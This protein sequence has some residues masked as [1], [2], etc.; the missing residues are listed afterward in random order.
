MVG[1]QLSQVGFGSLADITPDLEN[2]RYAPY[3]GHG[4]RCFLAGGPGWEAT[5]PASPPTIDDR[6]RLWDRRG[7]IAPDPFPI[8]YQ[9]NM[10]IVATALIW[11]L[12]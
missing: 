4:F 2:V 6:E 9:K 8:L 11:N 5:Y 7:E 1:V 3:S 10:R 12:A